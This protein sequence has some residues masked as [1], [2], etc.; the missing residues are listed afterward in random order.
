MS[1]KCMCRHNLR[2]LERARPLGFRG[3]LTSMEEVYSIFCTERDWS[4]YAEL[5]AELLSPEAAQKLSQE[6]EKCTCC[7]RHS[8][9]RPQDLFA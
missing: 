3:N 7:E 5:V 2:W 9:D 1:C 4:S 8:K 6:Y